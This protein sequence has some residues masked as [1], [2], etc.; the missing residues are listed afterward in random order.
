MLLLRLHGSPLP[1]SKTSHGRQFPI[2]SLGQDPVLMIPRFMFAALCLSVRSLARPRRQREWRGYL[3]FVLGAGRVRHLSV[4][5]QCLDGGHRLLQC[6][7]HGGRG[8]LREA[9]GTI[10]TFAVGSHFDRA[11]GHQ[12][13]RGYHGILPTRIAGWAWGSGARLSQVRRRAHHH[14]RGAPG[15]LRCGSTARKH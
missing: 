15:L 2:D 3:H 13:R 1:S 6:L 11:G 8:F 7:V 12:C 5:Y 10:T 9:D 14:H 4:R